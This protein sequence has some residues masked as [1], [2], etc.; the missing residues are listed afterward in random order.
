MQISKDYAEIM[1]AAFEDEM[2]KIA[3]EKVAA[4]SPQAAKTLGTAGAAVLGWEALRKANQ[5]RKMG[6]AMRLQQGY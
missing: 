3:A 2:Q 4:L 5:D 1:A 6:R